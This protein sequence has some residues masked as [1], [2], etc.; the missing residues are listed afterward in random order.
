MAVHLKMNSSGG[1]RPPLPSV[2]PPAKKKR[3]LFVA[4]H[5]RSRAPPPGGELPCRQEAP[6]PGGG[7]PRQ[8]HPSCKLKIP[9]KDTF[10]CPLP[11]KLVLHRVSHWK[12]ECF[13]GPHSSLVS[14][15]SGARI[16]A[17]SSSSWLMYSE[18]RFEWRSQSK[19]V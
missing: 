6:S 3:A 4:P 16:H 2:A 19:Q 8:P 7:L 18:W 12:D 13:V 5:P 10:Q 11:T 15:S 1:G 17:S 9:G 14:T